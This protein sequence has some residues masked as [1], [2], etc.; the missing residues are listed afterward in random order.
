MDKLIVSSRGGGKTF[1]LIQELYKNPFK[2]RVVVHSGEEKDRLIREYGLFVADRIYTYDEI[3]K[4]KKTEGKHLKD[5]YVDNADI[6]LSQLLRINVAGC[7]I[8][9]DAVVAPNFQNRS[10]VVIESQVYE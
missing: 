9:I 3:M 10:T 2:N 7:S 5:Y 6:L 4:G 8:T 1:K